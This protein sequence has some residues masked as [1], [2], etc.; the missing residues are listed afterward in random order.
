MV[1]LGKCILKISLKF[2]GD[3]PCRSLILIK[4]LCNYIG[5]VLCHGCSPVTV[6][7]IFRKNFPKNTL[8]GLLV[9]LKKTAGSYPCW[10][11]NS[12]KLLCNYVENSLCYGCSPVTVLHI[13]RTHF[14]KNTPEGLLLYLK[15][16]I[17]DPAKL[18]QIFSRKLKICQLDVGFL[19]LR[20]YSFFKKI[21][22]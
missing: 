1:F 7:H 12:I 8:E 15:E 13:F 17:F 18:W 11:V 19:L 2:T 16:L 20:A 21:A 4:L 5:T 6:L 10:S 9:Y 22:E 14:P 3:Y